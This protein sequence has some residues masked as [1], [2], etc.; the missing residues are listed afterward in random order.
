ML[1]RVHENDLRGFERR[2]C[3]SGFFRDRDAVTL[4][5]VLVIHQD[6]STGGHEIAV[7]RRRQS[8]C[9]AFS[10]LDRCAEYPGVRVDLQRDL[11][12]GKSARERR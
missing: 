10:G 3:N 12:L 6:P 4:R 8:I 1:R 5:D 2:N 11:I 9:D 7:S